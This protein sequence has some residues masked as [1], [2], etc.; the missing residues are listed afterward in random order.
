MGEGDREA[1]WVQKSQHRIHVLTQEV[2]AADTQEKEEVNM[3]L[4][5]LSLP[6]L[7]TSVCLSH[8]QSWTLAIIS[9]RP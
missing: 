4:T 1:K 6:F 2:W 7:S 8:Q 3:H 9:R 5:L